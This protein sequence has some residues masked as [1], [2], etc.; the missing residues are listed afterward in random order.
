MCSESR[1]DWVPTYGR[2]HFSLNRL[3]TS[4]GQQRNLMLKKKNFG[5]NEMCFPGT[6]MRFGEF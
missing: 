2:E 1:Q 6:T 3:G 5:V 4:D